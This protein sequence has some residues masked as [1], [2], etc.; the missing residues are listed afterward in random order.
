M[1]FETLEFPKVSSRDKLT[2]DIQRLESLAFRPMRHVRMKTLARFHQWREDLQRP[3]LRS[4]FD[5]FHNRRHALFFDR[6]IAVRTKLRSGFR[7]QQPAEL[8]NFRH[9][10]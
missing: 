3:S 10:R 4:R 7:P 8:I 2:V 9:R 6:Y 5:L 1:L